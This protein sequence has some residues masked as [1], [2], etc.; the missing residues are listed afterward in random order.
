MGEK[1]PHL[2]P[3]QLDMYARC[4]EAY[5]RRYIEKEV[6]APGFAMLRGTGVHAGAEHNFEQKIES[7]EDLPASDI[8]GAAVAG[9]E[10]AVAGGYSLTDD[11]AGKNVRDVIG[12][13][14][15][16]VVDMATLHAAEQAPDYQPVAVEQYVRLE[17]PDHPRDLVGVIDL[18]DDQ[19]RVIDFK[20]AGRKKSQTDADTS[21]Q[22]TV[23][24]AAHKRLTGRDATEVRLDTVVK[25]KTKTTRD[26]V[27][28]TRGAADFNALANRVNVITYAIESGTFT[29]ATPGTWWCSQKFCGYWDTCPFVNSEREEKSK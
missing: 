28:S 23:Y 2:S 6:I 25:T 26:V 24:A 22:L 17:L 27:S 19:D 1:K 20:T 12:E 4:P 29:P 15:D 18:M 10:E 7:H 11:E 21:T 13:Q 8:I 5:R 14:K 3:T 16:V 9:F